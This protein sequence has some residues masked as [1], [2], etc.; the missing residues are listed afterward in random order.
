MSTLTNIF[1][2]ISRRQFLKFFLASGTLATLSGSISAWPRVSSSRTQVFIGKADS[3]D[4]PLRSVILQGL[5]ELG[6]TVGDIKG[7]RILLKPNL[8]ETHTT[9]AHIN[10]HPLVV[11]AAADAFLYLG[12]RE[13]LVGEG[14]GHRRDVY[15]IL[16]ESGLGPILHDVHVPFFDLNEQTGYAVKNQGNWTSLVSLTFPEVFR[17]VDW[18][19]SMPKLKTH[20]WA[21]AT[22][23]MKNLF[24]VM[25]GL[26]Y[27]WPK[28]VLH[29]QGIHRS[30]LDITA[31]LKPHF[32]IAD[33]I[34]GM[35]GD[36]PIMGTPK[37]MGV[38]VMGKNLPAV[39][40]TCARLMGIDP[41]KIPYLNAAEDWLGPINEGLIFQRGDPIWALRQDF[42]LLGYIPAHQGLRLT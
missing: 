5:Q 34:V 27:G 13:V 9:S 33:G 41:Y 16:E 17:E 22:L 3:Y 36:G 35:E 6:V 32:A 26:Y 14:P 39:D 8:V 23:S 15:E 12:A 24:G 42:S 2:T 25:P 18:I 38:L 19:V 29:H 7:K 21:G 1:S 28:N 20:H 37:S 4:E 10:T 30:I 31:T 40:A 11:H